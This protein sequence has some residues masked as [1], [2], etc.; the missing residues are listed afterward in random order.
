MKNIK[1]YTLLFLALLLLS[2]VFT[3]CCGSSC[4]TDTK[5][6][7]VK[8]KEETYKVAVC[9]WMILKRQKLSAFERA[10]EIGSDGLEVD[11]G[12]LGSR[13]TFDNKLL[14]PVQ[15]KLFLDKSKETGI[16]I[17]SIA[18]S[19]FYAQNFAEREGIE[20]ILDDAINTAVLMG[21]KTI[22]L[23]LGVQ[24]DLI[25]HPERRGPMIKNLKLAGQKAE[26]AGVVIG[27]ETSFNATNELA[28]LQ[29][30]GS[31]AIKSYFNFS[32]CVQQQNDISEELKILGKENIAMIHSS[33]KDSVW[34]ENDP[35]IDLVK[36][37]STL[38]AMNWKG[39]LVIE[40]SRDASQPRNVLA[41]FGAN[42]AYLKKVFQT[43]P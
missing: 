37:K 8:E 43:N 41:N 25:K 5:A 34:L 15:R 13:P 10:A 30:I 9:D 26:A 22:F 12:G 18:M 23:P 33:G 32:K 35:N 19:G 20:R 11:L 36:I 1:I 38:D 14:D 24:G 2:P 7:T 6:E 40:R 21:V 42:S 31:P 39:W 3:S 4:K 28:F 16:E 27:I 17:S 29:E